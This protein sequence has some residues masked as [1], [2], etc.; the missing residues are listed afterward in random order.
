MTKQNIISLFGPENELYRIVY[1]NKPNKIYKSLKFLIKEADTFLMLKRMIAFYH[2]AEEF[3]INLSNMVKLALTLRRKTL[4]ALPKQFKFW[5]FSKRYYAK[6][7]V[8][9]VNNQH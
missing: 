5:E 8:K 7:L 1:G 9:I 2:S 4:K 6:K 3:E